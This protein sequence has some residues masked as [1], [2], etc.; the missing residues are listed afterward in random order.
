MILCAIMRPSP[1]LSCLDHAAP[2]KT[3]IPR[4]RPWKAAPVMPVLISGKLV[5]IERD[6][7]FADALL[8]ALMAQGSGDR[9]NSDLAVA[10]VERVVVAL[11][12]LFLGVLSL[13]RR[14][15]HLHC[16]VTYS[17]PSYGFL[18]AVLAADWGRIAR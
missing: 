5:A 17:D 11:G 8:L 1:D 9:R 6:A 14:F 7:I 12:V 15:S 16:H 18:D 13:L 2:R 10:I 3:Q 4:A